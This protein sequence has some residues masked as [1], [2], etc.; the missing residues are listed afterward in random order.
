MK[1][2]K[3]D[4]RCMPLNWLGLVV[5]WIIASPAH[6]QM[7]QVAADMEATVRTEMET[8]ARRYFDMAAHADTA[9]LAQNSVPAV[10]ASFAGIEAAVKEN[11][12]AFSQAQAAVRSSYLL[13]AEGKEPLSRAEF[14][15]GVFGPNGQT[16]NSIVFVLNSL[17]PGKYGV[18]ILDAKSNQDAHTLT[19]ILQET[20]G[21]WKLAGFFARASQINGHDGTWFAQRA[22]EFKA[23]GQ[24]HNAWFYIRQ[25]IALT[26]PA[27][28]VS[29]LAT[30]KLYDEAQTVQPN[31]LP[32]NG[33]TIDLS[34]GN[35]TYKLT[36]IYPAAVGND[37]DLVVKY[38]A[39]DVSDTYQTFQANV[40]VIKATVARF[41]E[42]RD[43]F[44]GIAARAVEPSGRDYGSM[45]PVKE[46]K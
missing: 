37:F 40:A 4:W 18:V 13:T 14:L 23:K 43:A 26:A 7:C 21:A 8:S 20:G 33:A 15:C 34:A 27:D 28:F 3:G 25:A 29:T 9:G 2:P 44:D 22:R 24:N 31:D 35:K 32:L 46:I 45:L 6:A 12:A 30:D 16:T 11:Q 38:Q 5:L 17:P 42:F 1:N 39:A 41:P 19:L 36:A 10:A